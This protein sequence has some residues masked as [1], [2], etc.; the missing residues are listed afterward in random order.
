LKGSATVNGLLPGTYTIKLSGAGFRDWM[1]Q[2]I[3][4]A[5]KISKVIPPSL[6]KT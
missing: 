6:S 1:G 2:V 3:I 5:G 4:A